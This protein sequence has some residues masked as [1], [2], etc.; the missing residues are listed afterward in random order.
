MKSGVRAWR[1]QSGLRLRGAKPESFGRNLPAA[2]FFFNLLS[3]SESE[4][5]SVDKSGDKSRDESG[6]YQ[7]LNLRLHQEVKSG[8]ASG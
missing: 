1:G 6:G 7:R 3:R 8:D 2:N 5:T 4:D